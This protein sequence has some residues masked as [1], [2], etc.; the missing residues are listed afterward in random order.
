M[1]NTIAV[2]MGVLLFAGFAYDGLTQ[3]WA[4]SVF[5][6]RKGLDLLDWVAFWR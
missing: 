5:L 3:D 1:T 2:A 4:Y 6:A